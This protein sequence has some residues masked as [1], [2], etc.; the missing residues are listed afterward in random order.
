VTVGANQHSQ[1]GERPDN[2]ILQPVQ[3]YQVEALPAPGDDP[4]KRQRVQRYQN[5]N[6]K[7]PGHELPDAVSN[8]S[9]LVGLRHPVG[10]M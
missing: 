1:Q 2:Q 6:G 4:V 7:L 8:V 3:E 5:C 9:I 10:N